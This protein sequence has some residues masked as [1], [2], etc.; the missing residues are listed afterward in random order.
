MKLNKR[1]QRWA[2]MGGLFLS[3]VHLLWLLCIAVS[4]KGMQWFVDWI[5]ELHHLQTKITVLPFSLGKAV[6]LVVL[7]F[8][9]GYALGWLVGGLHYWLKK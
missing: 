3:L 5:M 1:Y 6:I 2:L 8:V 4:Q 9:V 7:T